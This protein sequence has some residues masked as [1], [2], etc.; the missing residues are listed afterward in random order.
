MV[1]T[2]LDRAAKAGEMSRKYSKLQADL[3]LL[4]HYLHNKVDFDENLQGEILAIDFGI[5]EDD[6]LT[7]ICRDRE[8]LD[9]VVSDLA[10]KARLTCVQ[11]LCE[12]NNQSLEIPFYRGRTN[13][14]GTYPSFYVMEDRTFGEILI[15]K[16]GIKLKF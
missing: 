16:G 7:V 11:K 9:K 3:I 12:V 5:P 4:V 10:A 14:F 8:D 15:I 1:R 6:V 13:D 2:L